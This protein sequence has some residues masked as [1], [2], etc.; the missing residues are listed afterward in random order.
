MV[1]GMQLNKATPPFTWK[2]TRPE[3]VILKF[4]PVSK[5]FSFFQESELEPSRFGL[6]GNVFE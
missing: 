1:S 6:L 5:A 4:S 3:S 2:R